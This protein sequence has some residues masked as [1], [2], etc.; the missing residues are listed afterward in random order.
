MIDN[1]TANYCGVIPYADPIY[2]FIPITWA[3]WVVTILESLIIMGYLRSKPPLSQTIMDF[4][5]GTFCIVAI[6]WFTLLALYGTLLTLFQDSGEILGSMVAC[7]TPALGDDMICQLTAIFIVQAIL[8]KRP[9]MLENERFD[10]IIKFIS[11]FVI[12]TCNGC[13]HLY[14]YM[15]GI[16]NNFYIVVRGMNTK[17]S[18]TAFTSEINFTWSFLRFCVMI[19][20][21]MAF[22]ISRLCLRLEQNGRIEERSN[23]IFNTT[24][25]L[26]CS[27][28]HLLVRI[29][30][31]LL[32]ELDGSLQ[33]ASLIPMGSLIMGS[34]FGAMVI[35]SH[36]SIRDYMCRI[37][38]FHTLSRR[39]A[40]RQVRQVGSNEP[41]HGLKL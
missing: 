2:S 7:L 30:V 37:Y 13:L 24:G 23:N 10:T 18:F 31:I 5:I 36:P 16:H 27:I 32:M 41:L 34:T 26:I 35:K 12:P 14:A 21:L 8:V 39:L 22:V 9:T 1:V 25:V 3:L 20:L 38:P 19:P 6:P 4:M 15:T 40:I 33:Y 29:V 17:F 28:G 11:T